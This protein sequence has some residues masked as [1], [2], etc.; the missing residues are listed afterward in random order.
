MTSFQ[1]D[2]DASVFK[3]ALSFVDEFEFDAV[4]ATAL[5]CVSSTQPH[6]ELVPT[7]TQM[8]AIAAAALKS[9]PTVSKE[10]KRRLRAEKKRLLRKAGIYS[11]PNRVRNEQTR[12]IAYLREQMEKLQLDLHVLQ[13]HSKKKK[14]SGAQALIAMHPTTQSPTLWQEQAIRQQ[15]RREQA[16]CDNV[17]LKLAVERQRKVADALGVL[18]RK[19]TRQL[20]GYWLEIM[21]HV[22]VLLT[23]VFFVFCF[24]FWGACRIMS[25]RR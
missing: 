9:S 10:E 25:V 13:K 12:E 6:Q 15:R 2:D 5:P 21:V 23:C 11:D 19:R 22:L 17:R 18:V 24:L 1:Q 14:K 7:P 4:D 3:A 8:L 16:E 20:V